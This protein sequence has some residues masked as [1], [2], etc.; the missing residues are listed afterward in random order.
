MR[1]RVR[2]VRKRVEKCVD[3]EMRQEVKHAGIATSFR[4][5]VRGECW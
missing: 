3:I 5:M 4:V 1:L 2:D